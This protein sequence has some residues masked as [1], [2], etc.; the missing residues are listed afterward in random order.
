VFPDDLPCLSLKGVYVTCSSVS[1]DKNQVIG[2]EGVAV[3]TRL[4][5]VLFNIVAPPLLPRLFIECVEGAGARADEYEVP[6]DRRCGPDSAAGFKLP[7]NPG[8]RRLGQ[9]LG[10]PDQ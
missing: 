3:E 2:D 6:G 1:A 7:Q 10:S 8:G 5:A 4:V 9:V